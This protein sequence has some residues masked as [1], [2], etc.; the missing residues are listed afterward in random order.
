MKSET[1][2]DS[3]KG[4]PLFVGGAFSCEANDRTFSEAEI[5]RNSNV[6]GPIYV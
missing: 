5:R 4:C 6:T 2:L 3:L 1:M